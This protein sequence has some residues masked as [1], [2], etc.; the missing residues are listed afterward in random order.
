VGGRRGSSSSVRSA[1]GLRD[2]NDYRKENLP[3]RLFEDENHVD[4][5]CSYECCSNLRLRM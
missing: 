3:G 2:R 1:A 4:L 5:V